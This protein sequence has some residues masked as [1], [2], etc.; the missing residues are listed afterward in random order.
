ML[1]F[2]FRDTSKVVVRAMCPKHSRYNPAADGDGGIVGG[3][4]TCQQILSVWIA[5]QK[6]ESAIRDFRVI[7]EPWMPT[8]LATSP[9]VRRQSRTSAS[10]LAR[11]AAPF[12]NK[13][14]PTRCGC[15][16]CQ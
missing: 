2:T 8:K 15:Q 10:P 11:E 7:A 3:C 16:N 4:S 5:K 9:S 6:A 14:R 12:R 1:R 13:P